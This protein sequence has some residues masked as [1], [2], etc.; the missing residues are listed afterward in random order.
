MRLLRPVPKRARAFL[1]PGDDGLSVTDTRFAD[2]KL[3]GQFGT[4]TLTDGGGNWG[5]LPDDFGFEVF[6]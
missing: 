3:D 1:G 4:D 5:V 2:G 6:V